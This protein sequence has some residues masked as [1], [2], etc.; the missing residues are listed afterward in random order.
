MSVPSRDPTGLEPPKPRG[1]VRLNRR[2]LWAFG[3]I[4]VSVGVAAVV[5]LQAQSKGKGQIR[6]GSLPAPPPEARWYQKESDAV[7]APTA[8][9]TAEPLSRETP[10][11]PLALP[12][13]GPTKNP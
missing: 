11:P 5:A 9:P 10:P 13:R 8:P 7:F 3:I 4:V 2:G 6:T 1:I 12:D